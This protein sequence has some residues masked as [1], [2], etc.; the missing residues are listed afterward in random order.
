MK[1]K[2]IWAIYNTA[3]PTR[4]ITQAWTT[5]PHGC[6]G[7]TYA[8]YFEELGGTFMLY[9]MATDESTLEK[10]DANLLS[11]SIHYTVNKCYTE[12]YRYKG[13]PYW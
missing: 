12:R 10:V 6:Y 8:R 2:N 13:P 9:C 1:G 5:P 4:T 3:N 7:R 11:K